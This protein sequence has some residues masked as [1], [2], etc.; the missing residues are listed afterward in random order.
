MTWSIRDAKPSEAPRL[1]TFGAMLFRQAYGD[2]HP[3]PTL[4]DYL[5]S[6][7]AI[8]RVARTL[9]DPASTMIVVESSG[10][11]WIGYAELHQGAPTAR[12]T[13]ITN[14]LPGTTPIEIVRFY[15]D[16]EWHGRGVAQALMRACEDRARISD[17]DVIWLQT[18]QTAAQAIRFYK[19]EG[20]EIY[21]TAI[22]NFGDRADADFILARKLTKTV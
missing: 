4:S 7:F 15:V 16:K 9:E 18:W 14:P 13:M 3:E 12:T 6:S 11:T 20:F 19:K 5:A 1:A 10:G 2:T 21:G 17:C 8:P 22:F